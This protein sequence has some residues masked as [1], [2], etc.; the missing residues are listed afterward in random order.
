MV[1][2]QSGPKLNVGQSG[3]LHLAY[4]F[5]LLVLHS[6]FA[7][8]IQEL[9]VWLFAHLSMYFFLQ[10]VVLVVFLP[11]KGLELYLQQR[12][13]GNFLLALLIQKNGVFKLQF[14]AHW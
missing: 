13:Q 12:L 4:D 7:H 10:D 9:H 5:L 14:V 8:Q 11:V 6:Q 3:L 1:F 2:I